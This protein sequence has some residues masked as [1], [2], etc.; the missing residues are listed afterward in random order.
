[1]KGKT[2][3]VDYQKCVGC[4]SCEMMCS[5][6]H[7][8]V[9]APSQSRIRVVRYERMGYYVPLTCAMCEKPVCVRV[10]P[11]GAMIKDRQTGMV[12]IE[13]DRCIGCLQ[14][15]QACPFGNVN[16]NSLQGSIFKC[17]RCGG[18]PQCVRACWT[19]AL[20]YEPLNITLG[21]KRR[22]AGEKTLSNLG[23]ARP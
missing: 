7:D 11:A 21:Q 20:T 5:L 4:G 17:D 14:C 18:D 2:L 15:V 19:G 1:M 22:A 13:Q 8:G 12:N 16:F 9:C 23:E 6:V 3:M 10:C